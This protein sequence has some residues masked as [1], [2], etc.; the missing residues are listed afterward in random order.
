MTDSSHPRLP[1]PSQR[2][3]PGIFVITSLRKQW[4]VVMAVSVLALLIS[5][6]V[7]LGQKKIYRSSAVIQID[8]TP[9]RP[10]GN[11]VQG[12]VEMG[13]GAYLNNR[14]Y[15]ETQ[16]KVIQSHHVAEIVVNRLGLQQ[17]AA[18]LTN[19][20]P[21]IQV[22]PKE[23]SVEAAADIVISRMTVEPQKTSRL[24]TISFTD[25]DPARAERVLS[26]IVDSYREQNVDRV[27]SSTNSAV[28]WLRDQL[29]KLKRELESSEMALHNYKKKNNI[30]S[31]SMDDQSNMLREE[32]AKLNDTLTERKADREKVQSR[33]SELKKL[34]TKDPADLP[35][36]K[37]LEN[38][39]LRELRKD[40][41]EAGRDKAALIGTG[42][43]ENYPEV[44]AARARQE[45]SRKALLAEVRNIRTA[46]ERELSALNREIS[47]LEGLY[48]SAKK[49]ALELNLLE[50][51]YNRLN[52]TKANTEKLYGLVLDRT[53]QS[54][55]TLMVRV[56]NIAV[57]D[58]ARVPTRPIKPN[59]PLNVALGLLTGIALGVGLALG[60]DFL[61]RSVKTPDDVEQDLG[62]TF[63]GLLPMN[64]AATS[65]PRGGKSRRSR[66]HPSGNDGPPE[67]LV[68]RHPSSG[69]AEAARAIRTNLMFMSPDKPFRTFLITS[70]A[71]MEGKTTVATY[72]AIA[73]A[74][75]GQ[76]VCLVD[77]D[78]RRPRVHKVFGLNL[79]KGVT[80][81]L[82][83]V[84]SLA[85]MDLTTE[86]DN[87]GVLPCGPIPPNPSELLQSEAFGRL[88]DALLERFDRVVLDSPPLL[89]VTDGAILSTQVDCTVLVVRAFKTTRDVARQAARSVNDV[90][91]RVV[92]A[93]LNAVD[94]RRRE[95]SY[96]DYYYAKEGYA[97][98]ESEDDEAA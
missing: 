9:P 84:N 95:Y 15:Y 18:F 28:E 71:P 63:L 39:L 93:I 90:G 3:G 41:I 98:N 17:D 30:L 25:A 2:G 83:D 59:V 51:E 50:I 1:E 91:G 11:D 45:Q 4:L 19:A 35:A 94:L 26:I 75:A 86:V 33:V 85:Q 60:R 88:L 64:D 21:G 56:N 97:T 61:D 81:A 52:R 24:V 58:K 57:V 87:L 38:D 44:V 62:L 12:V 20:P 42:K 49:R 23:V 74:Q 31:L 46:Q 37:L 32:M 92:G 47:G 96:Y 80:T 54:D 13:T 16:Y 40:Y 14:E 69:M 43:G 7:T 67:L 10:L 34:A 36:Q 6:F 29:S 89:P 48:E 27:L 78:L 5:I 66:R 77:C 70:G 8:P 55:L 65:V 73:M 68:H 22:P 72:A 76:R 82:L 79:S 53:K